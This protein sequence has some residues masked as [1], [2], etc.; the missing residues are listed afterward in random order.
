M[1]ERDRGHSPV[2]LVIVAPEGSR[3]RGQQGELP[4]RKVHGAV[5]HAR[6]HRGRAARPPAATPAPGPGGRTGRASAERAPRERTPQGCARSRARR[7]GSASCRPIAA[8][9]PGPRKSQRR[10]RREGSNPA[11]GR[12]SDGN[13]RTS[14]PRADSRNTGEASRLRDRPAP[15]P[16]APARCWTR[17]AGSGTGEGERG[18][19]PERSQLYR[20]PVAESGGLAWRRISSSSHRT[21]LAFPLRLSLNSSARQKH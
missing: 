11:R 4:V 21:C 5:G 13:A 1:G 8:R 9:C 3:H 2:T 12:W 6:E 16:E 7:A 19:G 20:R 10:A 17:A 18:R 14:F 15:A